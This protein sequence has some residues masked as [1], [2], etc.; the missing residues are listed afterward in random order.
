MKVGAPI[1]G[2]RAYGWISNVVA[3]VAQLLLCTASITC[4]NTFR[5]DEQNRALLLYHLYHKLNTTK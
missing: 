3:V 5:V 4:R 1:D 2:G